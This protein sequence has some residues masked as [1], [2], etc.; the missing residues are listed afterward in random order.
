MATLSKVLTFI[1]NPL[2]HVNMTNE[3]ST[4]TIPSDRI[5]RAWGR[6]AD[7]F[8]LNGT[9]INVLGRNSSRTYNGT[10]PGNTFDRT[11]NQGT[12]V[13]TGFLDSNDNSDAEFVNIN[14][15]SESFNY[16]QNQ[17]NNGVKNYDTG[18]FY[19]PVSAFVNV[20]HGSILS[21]TH[22]INIQQI[23]TGNEGW[24]EVWLGPNDT[25]RGL[26]GHIELYEIP[27]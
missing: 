9:T 24:Y 5:G 12:Y 11:L 20:T 4:Y 6:I 21:S 26:I 18:S 16:S 25:I 8:I 27:S 1:P 7:N 13:I 19:V 14:I 15:T 10:G 3:E 22:R 17:E 23:G 2:S